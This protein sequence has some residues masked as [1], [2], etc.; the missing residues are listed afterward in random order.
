MKEKFDSHEIKQNASLG[1]RQHGFIVETSLWTLLWSVACTHGV[2]QLLQHI[3]GESS[4]KLH[5]KINIFVWP[6]TLYE[7]AETLQKY[8]QGL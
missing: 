8:C 3:N 4:Q 6:A 1:H 7:L 5:A 2:Q